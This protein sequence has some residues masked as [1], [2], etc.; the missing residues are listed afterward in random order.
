MP[1]RSLISIDDYSDP[2]RWRRPAEPLGL[3][4]CNARSIGRSG[5]DGSLRPTVPDHAVSERGGALLAREHALDDGGEGA[6]TRRLQG[7]CGFRSPSQARRRI[8]YGAEQGQR[9]EVRCSRCRGEAFEEVLKHPCQRCEDFVPFRSAGDAAIVRGRER[10]RLR[11][12]CARPNGSRTSRGCRDRAGLASCELHRQASPGSFWPQSARHRTP[13]MAGA[14]NII[15]RIGRA[16][17]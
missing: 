15:V 17:A 9:L 1:T 12:R 6:R 16:P 4:R 8:W 11:A 5:D 13:M 2:G 10:S 7:P 14:E 3:R